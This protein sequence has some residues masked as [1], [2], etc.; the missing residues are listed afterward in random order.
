MRPIKLVLS[1]FGPYG[2]ETVIDMTGLCDSSLFLIT[3]ET[4][5]GKTTIFDGIIFALYGVAS[6]SIRNPS[7]FR[8]KYCKDETKTFVALEFENNGKKYSIKRNPSYEKPKKRGSGT[9]TESAGAELILP[10]GSIIT[11]SSDVN[12]KIKEIIG[13]DSVQFSQIAMI[14]QGDFRKV[15][16]AGT[17]ER[18]KIFSKLFGTEIFQDLQERL[19][20]DKNKLYAEITTLRQGI[21]QY[22]DGIVISDDFSI[23]KE[24][25][26]NMYYG[27]I[28]VA[29]KKI[30]SLDERSEGHLED[31]IEKIE[32]NKVE[33][34]KLV[35]ELQEMRSL[36]DR[37]FSIEEE[38]SKLKIIEEQFDSRLSLAD[39][40][41]DEIKKY[42]EELIG[43]N[44]I[45]PEYETLNTYRLELK[46]LEK[47]RVDVD[48]SINRLENDIDEGKLKIEEVREE[49]NSL[50]GIEIKI[51]ENHHKLEKLM[52]EKKSLQSID[53]KLNIV[54]KI[55]EEVENLQLEYEKISVAATTANNLYIEAQ[56][57]FLD[58]QA[59]ILA[60][61]LEDGLPCPVCGSTSHPKVAKL[62]NEA[63][64]EKEL[65]GYK[66]KAEVLT[67]EQARSSDEIRNMKVDIRNLIA[68]IEGISKGLFKMEVSRELIKAEISRNT[69]EF[70]LCNT[71]GQLLDASITRRA[72]L[73]SELGEKETRLREDEE[74][75]SETK[76][77]L[78]VLIERENNKSKAISNLEEK[79]LYGSLDDAMN[80][81]N[82][83]KSNIEDYE[84]EFNSVREELKDIHEKIASLMGKRSEIKEKYIETDD[85]KLEPL[86]EEI[87]KLD[88][89]IE[90]K[91]NEL[92]KTF[93]RKTA[94]ISILENLK[95]ECTRLE[96]LSEKYT[97][98][99]NLSDT[100]NGDLS[101]KK[102][103]MIE[104]YVQSTYFDRI[105]RRANVRFKKMTGGQYEL[106]R[107]TSGEDLKK[108]NGLE[109]DL[110]DY[111]NGTYRRVETLSGGES[112]MASLSLALGLSDEIQ[113]KAGGI[114]L[115]SMFIDEGFGTLDDETLKQA[116]DTLSD[117]AIGNRIVGI[118]SHV[119]EL[120][121]RIDKQLRIKKMKN[122]G[123]TVENY[124][125]S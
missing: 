103:I 31:E 86:R 25:I 100:V 48:K 107:R 17:E 19:K 101:G 94:N 111:Y 13:V 2:S 37:L 81:A 6:G 114:K 18:R 82:K 5:A 1:A 24:D 20:Q 14:A 36:R 29:L 83:L 11:G 3:G 117:L 108:K 87:S 41:E 35:S 46:E 70:D 8:S 110:I 21:K 102:K 69:R 79:L 49:L 27:E 91:R 65:K 30:K 73:E 62:S 76:T 90:A 88:E 63:P 50:K 67:E 54:E 26:T 97:W 92:K 38:I 34:E 58:E 99:S 43:L 112:F 60:Q 55:Y 53:E 7:N 51:G 93:A 80:R 96:K 105:I 59:G 68:E 44:N 42:R 32:K 122:G 22:C 40:K 124:L 78:R 98:L 116:I 118:I 4:G 10:D 12:R 121:N 85:S 115:D 104:T 28:I 113:A 9:T 84:R 74:H 72:T 120:K 109:L 119:D 33:K 75:I 15:L 39:S 95:R 57:R 71:E 47:E 125:Q 45:L 89:F 61:K 123:S 66:K 16:F 64:S 106:I 56:R 23:S 52:E 77:R